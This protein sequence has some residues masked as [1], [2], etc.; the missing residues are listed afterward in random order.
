MGYQVKTIPYS[1]NI[2]KEYSVVP[3]LKTL[4]NES[5]VLYDFIIVPMVNQRLYRTENSVKT[6]PLQLTRL[7]N[8]VDGSH[9]SD[10]VSKNLHA[11]I[12]PS[13]DLE[14]KVQHIRER[15]EYCLIEEIELAEYLKIDTVIFVL[16]IFSVIGEASVD[17]FSRILNQYLPVY[18]I[19]I[20]I[21]V[22]I[23]QL[24]KVSDE[25][26]ENQPNVAWVAYQKLK[27]L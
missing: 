9:M 14:S 13:I 4:I 6:N 25:A 7:E 11:L 10:Y 12:K 15:A 24:P 19:N 22:P 20:I 23:I 3:C 18:P 1:L 27:R 26:E 17:N 16:P 5:S 2:G 21:K 8:S